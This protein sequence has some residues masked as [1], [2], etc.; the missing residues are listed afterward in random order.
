MTRLAMI[1]A[2]VLALAAGQ[3][4]AQRIGIHNC[5]GLATVHPNGGGLVFLDD[6]GVGSPSSP[7]PDSVY[8]GPKSTVCVIHSSATVSGN[9]RIINST[10][11]HGTLSGNVVIR[12]SVI[13]DE[14]YNSHNSPT[15]SGNARIIGSFVDGGTISGNAKIMDGAHILGSPTIHG[16]AK[17]SGAHTKVFGNAEV[18]G[19]AVVRDGAWIYGNG[20]VNSG[21]YTRNARVNTDQTGTRLGLGLLSNPTDPET[22]QSN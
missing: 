4:G 1:A 11:W 14:M 7:V 13:G 9:A 19:N 21:R 3:V 20:K 8:I 17:V 15:I 6:F 5:G 10:V 12:N 16:S 2:L 22:T 18:S